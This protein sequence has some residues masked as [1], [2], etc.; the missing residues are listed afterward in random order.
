MAET[1]GKLIRALAG[2]RSVRVLGV[3]MTSVVLE[4]C[5]KHQLKGAA[6]VLAS[7]ALV[8]TTL[9]SGQIKG[10]ERL[11][12]QIR[13]DDLKA[14]FMGEVDAKNNVRGVMR[15]ARIK[16]EP[17]QRLNGSVY[18][19][20]HNA[21]KEL[22]R[23]V[24]GLF[25]SS[26][27][28]AIVEHL[29]ASYQLDVLF[30]IGVECN[31]SGAPIWAGG[32]I[33][34]RLPPEIAS[35]EMERNRFTERFGPLGTGGVREAMKHLGDGWIGG[36]EMDVLEIWPTRWACRCSEHKVRTTIALLGATAIQE[37]VDDLGYA[38]VTC[39]FCNATYRLGVVELVD[40]IESI[41][42]AEEASR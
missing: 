2:G 29:E 13:F 28:Q 14:S 6:A 41:Q 16:W 36:E 3:E 8:A 15:P 32:F 7:E 26:V 40:L 30:R 19:I 25:H 31:E 23:G 35:H 10:E 38:A 24:T 37:M 18:A 11:T 22:Y 1:K 27:E 42:E 20:K 9:M 39:H 4:M 17:G 21:S 33:V 12:L 5:R 34:E